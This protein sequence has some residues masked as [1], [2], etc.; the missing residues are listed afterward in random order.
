MFNHSV[1]ASWS[2]RA[3]PLPGD[4]LITD[5]IGSLTHAVTIRRPRQEVWPWL[6]Q[7]GAGRGG[8]YSYDLLDNGRRPSASA[9]HPELQRIE[10]G[11]LMPGLPRARDGFRVLAIDPERSLILGWA[12]SAGGQM[13]T[14]TFFLDACGPDSTRLIVR[15]RG[16]RGYRLFGL[17]EWISTSAARLVHFLMERKQLLGIAAR[18]EM[19]AS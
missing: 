9:I 15:A 14:W 12:N 6:V 17:P 16:A 1:R 7:M 5:A 13:V 10:V 11:T 18:A 3:R 8:W 19:A 4:D 2:E